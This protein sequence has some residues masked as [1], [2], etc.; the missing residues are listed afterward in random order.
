MSLGEAVKNAGLLPSSCKLRAKCVKFIYSLNKHAVAGR[1]SR[2][3][4][5]YCMSI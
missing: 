5:I 4:G 1:T 3:W 2:Q